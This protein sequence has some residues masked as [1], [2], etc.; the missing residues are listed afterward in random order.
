MELWSRKCCN[1][2]YG[3][4]KRGRGGDTQY[5]CLFNEIL[6]ELLEKLDVAGRVEKWRLLIEAW[7][8]ARKIERKQ[9]K[10]TVGSKKHTDES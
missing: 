6:L 9:E 2:N 7:G 8:K 10:K 1:T 3:E 4:E 5:A